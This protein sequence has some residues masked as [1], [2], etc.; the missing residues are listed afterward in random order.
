MVADGARAAP[1]PPPASHGRLPFLDVARALAVVTMLVANLANVL[2]AERPHWLAHNLGDELLPLDL[3]APIF[4]FLI[5]VSL[6]L[7]LVRKRGS[8]VRHPR[9]L[10]LRRF[11]ALIVLGAALDAVAAKQAELRWGVLQTLGAGGVLASALAGAP[12]AAI[13]A[14]AG[15]IT[16]LYYGPGNNEVHRALRDCLPFLPLTLLGY[17][18]GRPLA[19][20]DRR[21][22]RRR[23]FGAALA[24]LALALGLETAGI[25]FNKVIG[26]SS[27]VALAGGTSALLIAVLNEAELHG[28][29]FPAA[30]VTLGASALTAWVLQY[31]LVFYPVAF[32]LPGSPALPTGAG[33]AAIAA[34]V[35]A[36]CAL[37]VGLAR[38]GIRIPL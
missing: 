17:V 36:V 24:C 12:D 23:A 7:F 37:T 20:G 35:L 22:F 27:F 1:S 30:V 18:V 11:L 31:L 9:S 13:L 8:L 26:T 10:A 33:L 32:V 14:I 21:A 16:A 34:S 2:L 28:W 3:P 4:Q 5:G 29:T 19:A 25:P 15:A 38:R 6:A